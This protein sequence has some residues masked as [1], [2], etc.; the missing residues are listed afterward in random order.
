VTE[1]LCVEVAV[2]TTADGSLTAVRT[3][4][5]WRAVTRTTNRW[6]VETDWW[7]APIRRDYRRCL[8]A[9]GDCIEL[10]VDLETGRWWLSRRYD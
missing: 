5:G 3:P 8:L 1:L 4:A 6:L 2:R 10:Y 9:E 7:R